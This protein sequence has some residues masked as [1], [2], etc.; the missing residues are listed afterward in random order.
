MIEKEFM[1]RGMRAPSFSI[2]KKIEDMGLGSWTGGFVDEWS[3]H[4]S[5]LKKL[6]VDELMI[7]SKIIDKEWEKTLKPK[8]GKRGVY[9]E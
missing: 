7:L 6:S 4:E 5:E 8:G 9:W 3:W 2:M 1:V